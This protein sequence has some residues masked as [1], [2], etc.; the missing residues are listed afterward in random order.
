LLDAFPQRGRKPKAAL[1]DGDRVAGGEYVV[2]DHHVVETERLV[3][4]AGKTA[5]RRRHAPLADRV[6]DAEIGDL[7]RLVRLETRPVRGAF[8]LG[9]E[10]P[11]RAARPF[12][13]VLLKLRRL[14]AGPR[15]VE[16]EGVPRPLCV[17][18]ADDASGVDEAGK[19]ASTECAAAESED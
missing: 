3:Q 2:A 19:A 14:G 15:A 9:I 6:E 18:A 17:Q 8:A 1:V 13:V 5:E 10:N 4:C 12:I 7:R 11:E 16:A